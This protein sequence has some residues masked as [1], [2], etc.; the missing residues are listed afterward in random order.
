MKYTF[1][2]FFAFV[3]LA[4]GSSE[5]S[6]TTAIEYNQNEPSNVAETDE[7]AST[8]PAVTEIVIEGNDMMKFNLNE[9]RVKSGSKVKLTLK[10]VGKLAKESMGHN[11]VL[12]KSGTNVQEFAMAAGQAREKDYISNESDI[13]AHTELIG[14]GAETSI[15]FDAPALGIYDFI[16]SFPGHYAMMKGQ[17]IVE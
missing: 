16:C 2:L 13:L 15:E 3:L 1:F 7:P 5:E 17:F 4:C 10:H 14:G 8:D 9:I 6:S 11:F 12:L